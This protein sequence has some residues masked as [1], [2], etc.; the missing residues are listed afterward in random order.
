[1]SKTTNRLCKAE[2]KLTSLRKFLRN[3]L[4]PHFDDC[5][6][7]PAEL[8]CVLNLSL[9]VKTPLPETCNMNLAH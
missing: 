4:H 2:L 5:S 9:R 3:T 8:Y 7:V 6:L 1:M